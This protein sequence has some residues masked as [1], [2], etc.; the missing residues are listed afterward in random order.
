MSVFRPENSEDWRRIWLRCLILACLMFLGVEVWSSGQHFFIRSETQHTPRIIG[1]VCG[2]LL[3]LISVSGLR[4]A[5]LLA[6]IGLVVSV[7]AM[8]LALL[9]TVAYN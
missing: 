1:A 8:L 2:L 9:P 3:F 7:P 5:R 6:C 4:T